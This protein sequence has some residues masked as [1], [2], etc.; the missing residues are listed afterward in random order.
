MTPSNPTAREGTYLCDELVL[1]FRQRHH[2]SL[3]I[4]DYAGRVIS[5]WSREVG[6]DVAVRDATAII[7]HDL[8]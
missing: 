4:D 7:D 8:E 1:H 2:P 6:I 3:P 5:V